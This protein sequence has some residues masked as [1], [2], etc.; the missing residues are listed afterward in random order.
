M[1]IPQYIYKIRDY[2][3]NIIILA[4]FLLIWSFQ[5]FGIYLWKRIT[6]MKKLLIAIMFVMSGLVASA[7]TTKSSVRIISDQY[8]FLNS[9]HSLST[10]KRLYNMF[11]DFMIEKGNRAFQIIWS[12][13]KTENN[14]NYGGATL[15]SH[16]EGEWDIMDIEYKKM[17][18]K[19]QVRLDE[20]GRRDVE[21]MFNYKKP[22]E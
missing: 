1:R 10:I 9:T 17:G 14:I 2:F 8:P 6:L 13:W 11:P 7:Q 15:V 19:L 5:H 22:K 16:R 3:S 18:V 12:D 20:R 4:P 21:R